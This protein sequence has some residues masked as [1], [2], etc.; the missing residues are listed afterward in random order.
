MVSRTSPLV[1]CFRT[2]FSI[3][4]CLPGKR[5]T[6]LLIVSGKLYHKTK[7]SYHKY[8]MAADFEN[9]ADRSIIWVTHIDINLH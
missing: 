6:I 1:R 2:N 4:V 3:G 9:T 7:A 8:Y 5:N